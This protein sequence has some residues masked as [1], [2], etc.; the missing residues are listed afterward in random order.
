[1]QRKCSIEGCE[2]EHYGK[3][4]CSAHYKRNRRHGDPLA[5]RIGTGEAQKF[6]DDVLRSDSQEC[7]EYP[8]YRNE[9]GYGWMRYNGG[10]LGSHV[11]VALRY[12]GPKPTPRHEVCHTCGNG[13]KGCVNPKHLYWGTRSDNMQDAIAHNTAACLRKKP[14]GESAYR[15]KYSD[16]ELLEAKERMQNGESVASLIKKTGMSH[17]TLYRLKSGIGRSV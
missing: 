9:Y 4:F 2:R 12:L 6:I 1:M 8:F 13:H 11:V 14:T 15:T 17:S 5:G 16:E 10:T 7:I 3:G